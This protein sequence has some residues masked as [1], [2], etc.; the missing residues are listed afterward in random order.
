MF[1]EN[2]MNSTCPMMQ[3][4]NTSYDII[5][6]I[7]FQEKKQDKTHSIQNSSNIHNISHH[8]PISTVSFHGSDPGAAPCWSHLSDLARW[9]DLALGPAA[10]T[11]ELTPGDKMGI[12]SS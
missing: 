9:K 2:K 6:G 10:A 12:L 7:C 11:Q 5:L 1:P 8:F 3:H 4:I